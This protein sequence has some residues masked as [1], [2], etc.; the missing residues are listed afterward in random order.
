M[1]KL[2]NCLYPSTHARTYLYTFRW[3]D[4]VFFFYFAR[5][6]TLSGPF[7]FAWRTSPP[8]STISVLPERATRSSCPTVQQVFSDVFGCD[9]TRENNVFDASVDARWTPWFLYRPPSSYETRFRVCDD[10]PSCVG[11]PTYLNC[12]RS[13]DSVCKSS[14]IIVCRLMANRLFFYFSPTY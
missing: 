6:K 7:V 13:P 12:H 4:F 3:F 10:F 5:L 11:R 2:V 1:V 14:P 8:I 9:Q